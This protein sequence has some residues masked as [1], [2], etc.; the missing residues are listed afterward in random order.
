MRGESIELGSW[1]HK[2]HSHFSGREKWRGTKTCNKSEGIN[3]SHGFQT[4][5]NGRYKL[6]KGPNSTRGLTNKDRSKRCLHVLYNS[7][8]QCKPKMPEISLRGKDLSI[9]LPSILDNSSSLGLYQINEGCKA[10]SPSRNQISDLFGRQTCLKPEKA[11]CGFRWHKSKGN[12]G[13]FGIHDK[14]LEININPCSS[15]RLSRIQNRVHCNETLF[16]SRKSKIKIMKICQEVLRSDR[17]S[18]RKLS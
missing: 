8:L 4:F 14:S 15:S 9:P 17:V 5:Q 10:T 2:P 18:V 6:S 3:W 13:E 11:S 7:N 12:F 1:L 16:I